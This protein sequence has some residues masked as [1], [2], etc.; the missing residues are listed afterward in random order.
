[1][2]DELKLWLGARTVVTRLAMWD[3]TMAKPER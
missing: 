3:S 2:V 1:M